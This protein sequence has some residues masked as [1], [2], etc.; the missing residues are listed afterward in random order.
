MAMDLSY[1]D[2]PNPG[3]FLCYLVDKSALASGWWSSFG[4]Q[5]DVA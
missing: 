5:C 2:F 3:S 1:I 4:D